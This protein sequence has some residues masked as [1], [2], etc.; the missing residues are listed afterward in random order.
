MRSFGGSTKHSWQFSAFAE[1]HST[2]TLIAIR[3]PSKQQTDSL[4]IADSALAQGA[5]AVIECAAD[6]ARR[7]CHVGP[8]LVCQTYT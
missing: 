3:A 1:N 2:T 7:R 6:L 5:G 4:G 8:G